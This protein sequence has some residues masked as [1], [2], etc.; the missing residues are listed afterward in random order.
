MPANHVKAVSDVFWLSVLPMCIF[1]PLSFACWLYAFVYWF[2]CGVEPGYG[3]YDSR[4][5]KLPEKK[6]NSMPYGMHRQGR[7]L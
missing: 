7:I 2:V 3:G 4:G 5:N 1:G 6:T